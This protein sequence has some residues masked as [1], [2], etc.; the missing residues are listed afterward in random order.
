M[1]A[2]SGSCRA[3]EFGIGFGNSEAVYGC[4]AIGAAMFMSL[5][6]AAGLRLRRPRLPS[7]MALPKCCSPTRRNSPTALRKKSQHS[8]FR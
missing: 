5:S 7:L 3:H 2:S 8:W 1:M 6:P 4:K